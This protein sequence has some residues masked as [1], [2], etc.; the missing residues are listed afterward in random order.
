MPFKNPLDIYNEY[1]GTVTVTFEDG[2]KCE[3]G[4]VKDFEV[5]SEVD[6][7]PQEYKAKIEKLEK[8]IEKLKEKQ[9][10]ELDKIRNAETGKIV[11]VSYYKAPCIGDR[12]ATHRILNDNHDVNLCVRSGDNYITIPSN[13][14]IIESDLNYGTK[15]ILNIDKEDLEFVSLDD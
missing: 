13:D 5:D 9:Q 6:M 3:M 8:K 2:T 14:W 7:T 1:H 12:G 11:A 4:F 15:L 10:L